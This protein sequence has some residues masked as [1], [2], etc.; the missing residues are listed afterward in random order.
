MMNIQNTL[1]LEDDQVDD[2]AIE[3]FNHQS[4]ILEKAI[5]EGIKLKNLLPNYGIDY[6]D[7]IYLKNKEFT[8]KRPNFTFT[9]FVSSKK[10]AIPLVSFFSGAGG[11]DLG[12]EKVGFNTKIMIEHNKTFCETLRQNFKNADI[13]GPPTDDGDVSKTSRIIELLESKG[14]EKGFEGVFVGGPPCQPFSIAANQRFNKS[15]ARFKRTGFNH[16]TNGGLLFDYIETIPHFRPKV[17]LIENVPGLLDIDGGEQ[18]RVAY[19]SLEKNG[20]FVHEPKILE[21]SDYG[22]PQ[23]RKRLFII[24]SRDNEFN[25]EI[26]KQNIKQRCIDHIFDLDSNFPNNETRQHE[27]LSVS[28]YRLIDYGKR[29]KLGRVDRLDPLSPS[30]TIIAGGSGGGGRSHLHPVI[31]R[32]LSPRECARLQTFPDDFIFTGPNARQFNQIGNAVPPL[33]SAHIAEYVIKPI[34]D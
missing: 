33:L 4:T 8:P 10:S 25:I 2:I 32:T 15:G 31:P 19:E 17:F 7:L 29:E 16:E 27:A 9:N 34:F 26:P 24:G 22:V 18:L 28:R 23:Y 5:N 12:F 14:I 3:A 20:Y 6:S 1:P 11:I 21:A 13:I 30:K